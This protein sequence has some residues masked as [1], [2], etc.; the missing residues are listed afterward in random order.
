MAVSMSRGVWM[1]SD[2]NV[3]MVV[4]LAARQRHLGY[5]QDGFPESGSADFQGARPPRGGKETRRSQRRWQ[6][7]WL[8]P[9]PGEKRTTA[10]P[11]TTAPDL[12][13]AGAHDGLSRENGYEP[14]HHRE[15]ISKFENWRNTG[16]ASTTITLSRS[17]PAIGARPGS[18]STPFSGTWHAHRNLAEKYR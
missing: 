16:I 9:V 8:W 1:S 11:G 5:F 4:T 7:D 2:K 3:Y 14:A 17:I 10:A 15:A 12:Y 13:S 18:G 6:R